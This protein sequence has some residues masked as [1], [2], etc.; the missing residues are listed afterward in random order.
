MSSSAFIFVDA[1]TNI[2]VSDYANSRIAKW[3]P[4]ASTSTIVAGNNG[5]GSGLNQFNAQ[6][7][8]FVDTVSN[9]IY[10]A[11]RINHRMVRWTSGGSSGTIIAGS[12]GT[13]GNTATL[14]NNP[15]AVL[16]DS[17]GLM[18]VL[19]GSNYRVLRFVVGN[20][21]GTTILSFSTGTAA[22]QL[23][24]SSFPFLMSFDTV[25]NIY[26]GDMANNRIQRYDISCPTTTTST[27]S[28]TS[29]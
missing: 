26:L 11:D 4:A 8:I 1:A 28:T 16:F 2:Y 21:T 18:Y 7:G 17:A 27:T 14:L 9:L 6:W 10:I 22:N 15:G 3:A 24:G 25:G 20:T 29:K 19:D 13:T 5:M 12:T 23:S